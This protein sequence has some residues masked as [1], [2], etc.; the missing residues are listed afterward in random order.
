M[1]GRVRGGRACRCWPGLQVSADPCSLERAEADA[2]GVLA[3]T[4]VPTPACCKWRPDVLRVLGRSLSRLPTRGIWPYA[5]GG[6]S[7]GDPLAR[8]PGGA[9]IGLKAFFRVCPSPWEAGGGVCARREGYGPE[10]WVVLSSPPLAALAGLLA[11]QPLLTVDALSARSR[12]GFSLDLLHALGPGSEFL[13]ASVSPSV[14]GERREA[15]GETAY[16]A[17]PWRALAFWGTVGTVSPAFGCPGWTRRCVC[18]G[19]VTWE[20]RPWRAVGVGE[21]EPLRREGRRH[22][23]HG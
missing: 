20:G 15:S 9:L 16:L 23:G 2:P 14:N 10:P 22:A 6:Y 12:P 8:G 3:G 21:W 17:S 13:W 18:R 11:G 5:Q 1:T 19:L 7:W 4:P